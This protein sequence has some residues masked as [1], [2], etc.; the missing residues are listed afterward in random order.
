MRDVALTTRSRGTNTA[1]VVTLIHLSL[2]QPRF[3]KPPGGVGEDAGTT[4]RTPEVIL[5]TTTGKVSKKRMPSPAE[6]RTISFLLRSA[7]ERFPPIAEG[8]AD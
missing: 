6:D 1:P 2:G 3:Q 4:R 7:L 5:I 8:P